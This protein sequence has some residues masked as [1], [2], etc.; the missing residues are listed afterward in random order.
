M[1]RYFRVCS[2]TALTCCVFVVASCDSNTASEPT[3]DAAVTPDVTEDGA[4]IDDTVAPDLEPA[5]DLAPELP[6]EP[7][8]PP[9]LEIETPAIPLMPSAADAIARA[10]AWL[11][12]DL[13]I[14]FDMLFADQQEELAALILG[15]EDPRILDEVAFMIAHVSPE[16][17][18][19]PAFY[20]ELIVES[21]ADLYA[22]DEVLDYVALM[23]VGVLD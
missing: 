17:L 8:A 22:K 4:S 1:M 11:R 16:I 13:R 9:I 3:P 12:P 5:E 23:D 20:P 6:P 14:Q 7:P 21:A 19:D 15:V 2:L 10:P 18:I